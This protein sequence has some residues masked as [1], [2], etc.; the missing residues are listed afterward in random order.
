MKNKMIFLSLIAVTVTVSMWTYTRST[1]TRGISLPAVGAA[2]PGAIGGASV[3]TDPRARLDAARRKKTEKSRAK[4]TA[5][6]APVPARPIEWVVLEGGQ[7]QMGTDSEEEGFFDA[8]PVQDV[9]IITLEMSRT[10]VTVAQYAE[11]VRKGVCA[12]PGTGGNCNWGRPGREH[13]PVNCVNWAQADKYAKFI[14]ARLPTEAEFEYAARSGGKNWKYPW[15]DAEPSCEKA[16]MS[17]AAGAGCSGKGT[18]PVCSKPEGS[19]LQG[20]CDMAGNVGQWVEDAYQG[21]YRVPGEVGADADEVLGRVVRGGAFNSDLARYLR[22]SY[23]DSS[24]E[25]YRGADVGFRLAR[26]H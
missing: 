7:Y 1:P 19:T 23:R 2:L 13:H 22:T 16:V 12:K 10:A 11:C 6:A 25:G 17:A 14:G 15:G 4:G 26:S 20:L 24:P 5:A 18:M 9:L 8:K 21:S 3:K